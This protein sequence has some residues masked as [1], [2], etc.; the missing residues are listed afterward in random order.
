MRR[1]VEQQLRLGL[2]IQA[3]GIGAAGAQPAGEGTVRGFE[4]PEE[5]VVQPD[6]AGALVEILER[7]A[8]GESQRQ[9][10]RPVR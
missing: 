1:E 3:F 10:G 9:D 5:P 7:E 4:E 6:Q 2:G 8:V